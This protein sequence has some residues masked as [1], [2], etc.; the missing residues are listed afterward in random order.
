MK[1]AGRCNPSARVFPPAE[2]I[3]PPDDA[4]PRGPVCWGWSPDPSAAGPQWNELEYDPP[5]RADHLA[6]T[7][8]GIAGRLARSAQDA[9]GTN[10]A[11]I[12]MSTMSDVVSNWH[13]EE[14]SGIYLTAEPVKTVRLNSPIRIGRHRRGR[15]RRGRQ[16]K[17]LGLLRNGEQRVASRRGA[18]RMQHARR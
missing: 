18:L 10:L 11:R 7:S 5:L 17:S 8:D 15:A 3:G 1:S 16:W 12:S 2:P 6:F 14:R 9:S 4:G 13:R